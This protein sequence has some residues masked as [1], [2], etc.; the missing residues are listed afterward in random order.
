M[1]SICFDLSKVPPA[2]G[3]PDV[4]W[5]GG[6]ANAHLGSALHAVDLDGGNDST[7]EVLASAPGPGSA[8]Q[9][10]SARVYA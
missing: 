10:A 5:V 2:A 6:A 1:S 4:T 9:R 3:A 8:A 7:A